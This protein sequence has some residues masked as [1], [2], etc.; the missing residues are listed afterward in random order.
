MSSVNPEC[1]YPPLKWD[2]S[3]VTDKQI[4]CAIQKMKPYKATC[5]GAIPNSVFTHACELLVPYFGPVFCATD[6]LKVY[7]PQWQIM[8]TPILCKPGKPDYTV[9][10]AWQPIVL[11]NGYSC[12]LNSCQ[13]EDMITM[14]EKCNILPANHFGG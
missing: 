9:P 12:L 11:S 14:C 2:F 5:P 7:P 13:T 4:H 1:N 6:I 3:L 10:G 8:E